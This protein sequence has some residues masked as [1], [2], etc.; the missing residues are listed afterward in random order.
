MT[1][2][3]TETDSLQDVLEDELDRLLSCGFH[4]VEELKAQGCTFEVEIRSLTTQSCEMRPDGRSVTYVISEAFKGHPEVARELLRELFAATMMQ[5]NGIEPD[6]SEEIR[7]SGEKESIDLTRGE[8]DLPEDVGGRVNEILETYRKEQSKYRLSCTSCDYEWYRMRRSKDVKH[9][10]SRVCGRC[11]EDYEVH[12]LRDEDEKEDT[13]TTEPDRYRTHC[14]ECDNEWFYKRRGKTIKELEFF[15]CPECEVD[16]KMEE[17]NEDG[18]WTSSKEPQFRLECSLCGD[19]RLS[20]KK[21]R[22]LLEEV[23]RDDPARECCGSPYEIVELDED[24]T[25]M[26]LDDGPVTTREEL[27]DHLR[28]V[29]QFHG[30]EG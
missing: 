25:E 24:E 28:F 6:S 30:T 20:Y 8:L 2:T 14:P 11:G 13:S 21:S 22:S 26:A 3:T 23:Y 27:E 18:E 15:Q 12:D 7:K 19:S 5:V 1:T 4:E 9:A 10:D 16:L 17:L 29:K